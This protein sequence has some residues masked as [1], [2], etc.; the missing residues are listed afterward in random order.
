MPDFWTHIIGGEKLL[1]NIKDKP[2]QE[3]VEEERNLYNF[4]CQGPDFFFYNDFWPW[5]RRK[6]GPEAGK[7]IQLEKIT[8]LFL[9]S[10]EF[11]KASTVREE[12]PLAMTHFTGF[13]THYTL[14][15][16]LHPFIN[17]KTATPEEHKL[18]EILIDCYL[19]EKYRG[20]EAYRLSTVEA[21]DFNGQ[22][23]PVVIE[24]FSL[25]LTRVHGYP[26]NVGFIEEAYL[27][28]K[29][30]LRKFYCPGSG[31]KRLQYRII[32]LFLPI[33]LFMFIYPIKP[34]YS[35]LNKEEWQIVE[36]LFDQG[37]SEAVE[38]LGI[39]FEFLED[40]IGIEE[41]VSFFPD[42]SFEGE[43]WERRI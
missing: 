33:N 1:K 20:E 12:F 8:E 32:N 37:V 39:I 4:G 29:R 34:D 11:L 10:A 42:I 24:Y 14:D 13:L 38:L 28:M 15:K 27:D 16:N 43:S 2:F 21:I 30:A 17:Y 9:T 26:R 19:V 23:P 6:R 35:K 7:R 40:R 22:L 36:E 5:L 18:L 41:L 25:I 3:M 31:A